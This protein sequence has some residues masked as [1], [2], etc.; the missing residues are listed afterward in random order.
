MVAT[1]VVC[2]LQADGGTVLS[3]FV[4]YSAN[5]VSVFGQAAV[6]YVHSLNEW[7]TREIKPEFEFLSLVTL[8]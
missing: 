5:V 6:F 4:H 7:L 1:S 3:I 8:I 2:A